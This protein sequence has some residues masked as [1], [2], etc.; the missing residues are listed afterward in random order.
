MKVPKTFNGNYALIRIE[1]EI[2]I[3]SVLQQKFQSEGTH[4]E[5]VTST[6]PAL[7]S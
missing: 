6:T 4:P 3:F 5:G 2:I 1:T 7:K